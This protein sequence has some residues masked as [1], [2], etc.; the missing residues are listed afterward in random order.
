[1]MV[2]EELCACSQCGMPIWE[3]T[4]YYRLMGRNFCEDCVRKARREGAGDE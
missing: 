4:A 3:D 2:Q 1:M